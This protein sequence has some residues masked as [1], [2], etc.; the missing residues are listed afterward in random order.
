[1]PPGD[2]EKRSMDQQNRELK[3]KLLSN[4]DEVDENLRNVKSVLAGKMDLLENKILQI[5]A[6]HQ[7]KIQQIEAYNQKINM[8]NVKNIEG[9]LFITNEYNWSFNLLKVV[10]WW[11]AL[12]CRN[13]F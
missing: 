9:R 2:K 3:L 10:F 5:E 7:S 4:I 6:D 1:M 13:V 12:I 8:E 11:E